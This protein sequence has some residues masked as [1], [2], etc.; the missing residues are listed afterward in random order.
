VGAAVGVLLG[1][2]VWAVTAMLDAANSRPAIVRVRFIKMCVT[3]GF[4]KIL[5][6]FSRGEETAVSLPRGLPR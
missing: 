5:R 4:L 2:V 6:D 3:P 1:E